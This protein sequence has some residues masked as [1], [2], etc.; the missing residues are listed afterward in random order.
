VLLGF[1]QWRRPRDADREIDVAIVGLGPVGATAALTLARAGLR[2]VV[3]EE[4]GRDT[5]EDADVSE[6][7]ASTFHPPTLE[8]LDALGVG[9]ELHRAG[10]VSDT[11]QYRDR[12]NGLVAHF[13]LASISGDTRFPYRLQSEQQN[14]VRII[15]DRLAAMPGVSVVHG[16]RVRSAGQ[17]A[18]DAAVSLL[19]G[20]A[21][22]DATSARATSAETAPADA[23]PDQAV[24]CRARWT[25]A[26]DGAHSA[27]RRSLGVAFTGMTYPERFLV[28]STTDDFAALIPGIASVNYISDPREWL[29]LLRT[30]KHWRA[31]FPISE[32]EAAAGGLPPEEVERRLQAV[33]AQPRPYEVTHTRIYTVHQRVAE[34]FRIG[35]V[36]LAG[37]AAHINNPLG[38]MGMNSGIHDA[39]AACAAILAADEGDTGPLDAYDATRSAVA[40]DYV[41]VVTHQNWE[42]LQEEDPAARLRQQEHMRRTAADPELARAHLLRS[43]MLAARVPEPAASE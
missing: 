32:N 1:D 20:P 38:G 33:V 13:D 41:R 24:T 16:A 30:P 4:A 35:R 25:I 10:L 11:Y 3:F 12:E 6:S 29:V 8:I 39:A 26:A 40:H 36:L 42:V 19:V 37:D 28:V 9:E 18:G 31:L 22:T 5:F 15:R 2:V 34:T 21:G 17:S 14:L 23:V 27:V 43:S 7:R